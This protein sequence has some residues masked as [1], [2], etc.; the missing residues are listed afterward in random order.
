M[1]K[2]EMEKRI[3]EIEKEIKKINDV[4]YNSNDEK[5]NN[6]LMARL[7]QLMMEKKQL[8]D[9]LRNLE[10]DFEPEG[11][12]PSDEPKPG[13]KPKS[14]DEPKKTD[15][16]EEI[17][18]LEAKKKALKEVKIKRINRGEKYLDSKSDLK[19]IQREIDRITKKLDKL[20]ELKRKNKNIKVPKSSE[21]EKDKMS[22]DE[23]NVENE[24][25]KKRGRKQKIKKAALGAL[26]AGTGV[27]L[28]FATQH[29]AAGV[30]ISV[31]RLGYSIY[32]KKH[33]GDEKDPIFRKA[34]RVKAP[35]DSNSKISKA[36]DKVNNVLKNPNVQIFIDGVAAGYTIGTAVQSIYNI[37]TTP[38]VNQN[39][40]A[41][42]NNTDLIDQ[43][44]SDDVGGMHL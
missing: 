1:T 11:P 41:S 20:K 15:L 19:Q 44:L 25:A 14:G 42:M 7:Q 43:N 18:K 38:H 23:I 6:E 10:P 40:I 9:K 30:I 33:A 37:F 16:D 31:A 12:K 29:N 24:L 2:E 35:K 27:A 13:E 22:P 3:K 36:V 26:G 39:L 4:Y 34:G 28:S 32:T 5:T 8:K 17:K 21:D